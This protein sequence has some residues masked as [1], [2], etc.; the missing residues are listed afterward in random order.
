MDK[1]IRLGLIF[2]V[3]ANWIGGTYYIL[4]LISALG[5]LPADKQPFIT[6]LS[7]HKS[8]FAAAQKTGYPFLN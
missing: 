8:D 2:T 5:T 7:K 4:N 1:R 3:D 6:I